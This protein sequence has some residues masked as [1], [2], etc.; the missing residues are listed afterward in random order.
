MCVDVDV[1]VSVCL[2]VCMRGCV[3]LCVW[4]CMCLCVDVDKYG[5]V[6][7]PV[8]VDTCV[9]GEK[10]SLYILNRE[11]KR[12]GLSMELQFA[13][14]RCGKFDEDIDN[15]PFQATPDVN[16]VRHT[17]RPQLQGHGHCIR[18]AWAVMV[19]AFQGH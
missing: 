10:A 15:C 16:N 14:T 12:P 19:T 8:C 11:K 18:Q 5:N 17:G 13:Q 1:C 7:V 9:W 6:C 4:I 3:W 2:C